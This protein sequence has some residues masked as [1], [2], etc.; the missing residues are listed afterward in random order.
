MLFYF[1]WALQAFMGWAAELYPWKI[2]Q[3]LCSGAKQLILLLTLAWCCSFDWKIEVRRDK[4]HWYLRAFVIREKCWLKNGI[5]VCNQASDSM[6]KT[7][8]AVG[9]V[10]GSFSCCWG[11]YSFNAF[12]LQAWH[13]LKGNKQA[14]H[15]Y[16]I[17]CEEVIT[18]KLTK[19]TFL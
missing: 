1:F 14:L 2:S 12:S 10:H 18:K 11:P 16:K 5:A 6:S 9:A 8:Q 15:W 13:Y 19:H 17:Y 7:W 3:I 4:K